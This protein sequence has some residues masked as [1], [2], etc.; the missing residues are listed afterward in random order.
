MK[1]GRARTATCTPA[2]QKKKKRKNKKKKQKKKK[3]GKKKGDKE[4]K[5]DGVPS[6]RTVAYNPD[7]SKKT[8]TALPTAESGLICVF[9]FLLDFSAFPQVTSPSPPVEPKV[10]PWAAQ[11]KAEPYGWRPATPGLKNSV[12]DPSSQPSIS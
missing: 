6:Y 10:I 8:S 7:V 4:Q 12:L 2:R 5:E 3:N 1:W 9:R 11:S